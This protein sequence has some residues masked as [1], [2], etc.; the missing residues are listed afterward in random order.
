MLSYFDTISLFF[1]LI[2]KLLSLYFSPMLPYFGTISLFLLYF[3]VIV[4]PLILSYAHII[5]TLSPFFLSYFSIIII[6]ILLILSRA[7]LFCHYLPFSSLMS[8]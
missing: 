2:S 5:L 8:Q 4:I 1:F 3:S 7:P 6:I